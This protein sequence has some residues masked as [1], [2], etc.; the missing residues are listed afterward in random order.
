M[1]LT[2]VATSRNGSPRCFQLQE[3]IGHGIPAF[4]SNQTAFGLAA[5]EPLDPN[6]A[7]DLLRQKC[8]LIMTKTVPFHRA[9]NILVWSGSALFPS[10]H[11]KQSHVNDL[12][13]D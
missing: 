7:L 2:P 10:V 6:R 4:R 12:H 13:E 3:Q 5:R 1:G 9:S 11:G 8:Q